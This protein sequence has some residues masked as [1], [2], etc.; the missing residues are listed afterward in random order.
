[1]N[2]KKVAKYAILYLVVSLVVFRFRHDWATEGDIAQSVHHALLLRKIGIN[3]LYPYY[4]ANGWHKEPAPAG[5]VGFT[6]P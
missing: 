4:W 1:M 3:E 2:W 5:T 6:I